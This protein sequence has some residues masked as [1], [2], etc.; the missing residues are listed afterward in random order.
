VQVP[1]QLLDP[2]KLTE[3]SLHLLC[4][5]PPMSGPIHDSLYQYW[6]RAAVP[7]SR[8][9]SH[10]Y[11]LHIGLHQHHAFNP[12]LFLFDKVLVGS[13]PSH[14]L[15]GASTLAWKLKDILAEART[16]CLPESITPGVVP[17]E[18]A[19]QLLGR[20]FPRKSPEQMAAIREC[21]IAT[22][23][24][25]G[26][27]DLVSFS[28]LLKEPTNHLVTPIKAAVGRPPIRTTQTGFQVHP[29]S[30]AAQRLLGNGRGAELSSASDDKPDSS[31]AM[32]EAEASDSL[33]T[34]VQR[35]HL[36]ADS[37]AA[38]A[39]LPCSHQGVGVLR[40]EEVTG[41]T[42]LAFTSNSE[43]VQSE[44]DTS[45][46]GELLLGMLLQ[47]YAAGLK[48]VHDQLQAAVMAL[49]AD[50]CDGHVSFDAVR[51]C[52]ARIPMLSDPATAKAVACGSYG[53][54]PDFLV[55]RGRS[56][57]RQA[58]VVLEGLGER[59]VRAMPPLFGGDVDSAAA[60]EWLR[61]LEA[62]AQG[63][64]SSAAL[65]DVA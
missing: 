33:G 62:K 57:H 32:L 21:V 6:Q 51:A 49:E 4:N 42:Q 31:N 64:T 7:H 3:S 58:P 24:Y 56:W 63:H 28:L 55:G 10:A 53:C 2:H 5:V 40:A 23:S 60:H 54:C 20:M 46:C 48:S 11:C 45:E 1:V 38:A 12:L 8:I 9:A 25:N 35:E 50:A 26:S 30:P 16:L 65:P 41:E 43:G 34:E 59:L 13:W 39:K 61:N 37:Q 14:A 17:V 29:L 27:R 36:S 52:V 19:M 44:G 22:G 18:E 47:Q 15:H